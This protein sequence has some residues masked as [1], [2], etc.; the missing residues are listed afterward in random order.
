M[1]AVDTN[2]LVQHLTRDDI[3]QADMAGAFI[4][5]LTPEQPGFICREVTIE[6]VWVLERVYR[7]T[8]EQ[9]ASAIEGLAHSGDLVI[10]AHDDVVESLATYRRGG[11]ADFS[12]LM[13][14]AAARRADALPVYTFDRRLSRVDGA[15]RLDT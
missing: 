6:T 13:I 9:I 1:V 10:E 14:V 3:Q 12:D 8:R 2:I 5:S 7:F 4:A 15:R 11:G